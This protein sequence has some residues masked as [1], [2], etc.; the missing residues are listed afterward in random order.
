M[1]AG[2]ARGVLITSPVVG[3]DKVKRLHNLNNNADNLMIFA[4][5]L[6]GL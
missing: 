6:D 5:N 4:D 3:S 2:G 1:V